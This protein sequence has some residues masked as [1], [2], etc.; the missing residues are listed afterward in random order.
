[1]RVNCNISAIVANNQ[2]S[3]SQTNLDKAI[4]RLS[5]G[6]KIN[7]A[8]DDA[9]GMAI[10]NKLHTQIKGLGQASKNGADGISVVETAESA[11][12][13]TQ[14]ILQRINE[15]AVQAASDT[16]SLEDRQAIQQEINSLL[17][18]VDRISGATEF[19]TTPLLD[20]S[21]SRRSYANVDGVSMYDISTS[22]QS[23]D[24][25][26]SIL[27]PGKPASVVATV[28]AG[29]FSSLGSEGAKFSIN[30]ID[31][32][33]SSSDTQD[34]FDAK[35]LEACENANLKYD[36]TNGSIISVN[37]G[38][39]AS[40][41]TKIPDELKTAINIPE[42]AFGSDCVVELGSGFGRT[43]TVSTSG[44]I[45]KVTDVNGFELTIEV[46]PEIEFA[47][48]AAAVDVKQKV[49]D[50]GTFTVQIGA[51]E[52]Q[53]LD[54]DIPRVNSHYLGIDTINVCSQ[55]GASE[56]ITRVGEAISKVA[57]HRSKLGAYENRLDSSVS[58]LD[59]YNENIT[60]A[61]SRIEDVDMAEAMTEYTSQNVISQAAISVLAQ[62][63]ERPQSILQLLQ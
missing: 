26:Y 53:S 30:G 22:V 19:N 36:K 45:A 10:A 56:A 44:N 34:T 62:A 17:E 24:Y 51:N 31:V 14:A 42:K 55:M 5:S 38:A 54:I 35:M 25:E 41:V 16:N 15:L 12:S 21:L 13:E 32:L 46:D 50:M 63:N 59:A 48:G 37:Y 6:L 40:I 11:L 39:E 57:S 7:H 58:H 23:G 2:L 52:G 61:V 1:M 3:K 27:S 18:E 4:E 43:A 60:A 49:T 20:G 29:A 33:V 47:P 8:E 9:A 28:N